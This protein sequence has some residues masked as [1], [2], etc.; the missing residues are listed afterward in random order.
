MEREYLRTFKSYDLEE[1]RNHLLIAGDLSG[2]CAACRAL[3]IDFYSA[4]AC[5]QCGTPFKYLASRRLESHAGERFH[6]ARR[7]QEKR[8]DLILM[9]YSDYTK[10][11]GHK[12]A[13]DFFA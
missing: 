11:I 9:D 5:P 7:L 2:D 1:V 10:A 3:G 12:K 4:T 6:L 13:R 8:P